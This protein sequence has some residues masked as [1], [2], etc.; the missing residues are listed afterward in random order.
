LTNWL[1]TMVQIG[2]SSMERSRGIITQD[3]EAAGTKGN[4]FCFC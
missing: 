1:L 4:Y 2:K 3:A